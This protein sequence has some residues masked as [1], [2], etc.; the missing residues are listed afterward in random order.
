MKCIYTDRDNTVQL[1]ESEGEHNHTRKPGNNDNEKITW[2]N[3]PEAERI[4]KEGVEHDDFP[5]HILIS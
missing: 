4:V 3:S 2:K 5:A 1:Y